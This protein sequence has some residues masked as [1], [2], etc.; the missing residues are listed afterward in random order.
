[1]FKE[2]AGKDTWIQIMEILKCQIRILYMILS[3]KEPLFMD[4]DWNRSPV[5]EWKPGGRNIME[6]NYSSSGK[7]D[8][9]R[10]VVKGIDL[11]NVD[12]DIGNGLQTYFWG[13]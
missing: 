11:R 13:G 10:I 12:I 3:W 6:F 4:M 7:K 8:N 2:Q 9:G 1:M 5:K